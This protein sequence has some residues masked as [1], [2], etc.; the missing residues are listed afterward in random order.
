MICGYE[1]WDHLLQAIYQKSSIESGDSARGVVSNTKPLVRVTICGE[2]S[3]KL[4]ATWL[5]S[6][7]STSALQICPIRFG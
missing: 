6:K 7:M 1:T 3:D 2:R 4:D 5:I